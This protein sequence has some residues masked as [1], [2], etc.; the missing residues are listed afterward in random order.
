METIELLPANKRL[1]QIVQEHGKL[2]KLLKECPVQC[3]N[4]AT[5]LFIESMDGRHSRWIRPEEAKPRHV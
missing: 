1:K 2:W 3:F 4:G 5:G